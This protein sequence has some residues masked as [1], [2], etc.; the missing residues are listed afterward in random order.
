MEFFSKFRLINNLEKIVT[1]P[2]LRE[3]YFSTNE[4]ENTK[5][6]DVHLSDELNSTDVFSR[7]HSTKSPKQTEIVS[8]HLDDIEKI[9]QQKKSPKPEDAKLVMIV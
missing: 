1:S 4:S 2:K 9:F 5:K 3:I 7:L 8:N 6:K